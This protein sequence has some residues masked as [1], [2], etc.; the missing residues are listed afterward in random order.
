LDEYLGY[1]ML[2]LADYPSKSGVTTLAG[3]SNV[4]EASDTA[5]CYL[6]VRESED[7]MGSEDEVLNTIMLRGSMYL[8]RDLL[9]SPIAIDVSVIGF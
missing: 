9:Y 8:C 3:G 1:K 2:T 7:C 6:Q 4:N 5:A